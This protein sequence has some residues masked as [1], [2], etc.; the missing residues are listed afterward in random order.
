MPQEYNYDV[1]LSFAGEDREYVEEVAN[2]LHALG[3]K[4]FY[5]KYEEGDL[6][7]KDLYTHLDDVYQRH[8][9]YCVMFISKHY[10]AKLWTNHERQSAQA[11]ALQSKQEYILPVRFDDTEVPGIRPTT[12]YVEASHKT[13]TEL[14]YLISIKIGLSTEVREIDQKRDEGEQKYQDLLKH[15]KKLEQA[16][17]VEQA[18]KI[19]WEAMSD[20]QRFEELVGKVQ[21]RL[22]HLNPIVKQAL[23]RDFRGETLPVPLYEPNVA[24]HNAAEQ[25][26]LIYMGER[27][28]YYPNENMRAI[29]VAKEA[30]N[31]LNF[32]I[33][34]CDDDFH[35]VFAQEYGYEPNLRLHEFWD[36]F[37]I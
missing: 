16:K 35:T 37:L 13:P 5:D 28:V 7:G 27:E 33:Q 9:K 18:N 8:A 24:A 30:L 36:S 31:E 17:D 12:S 10:A 11:R 26:Y 15:V 23:F 34:N 22:E 25:G 1:A 29:R 3:G 6:W 20:R 4:V 19:R 14:A 32:F 2:I 21:Q